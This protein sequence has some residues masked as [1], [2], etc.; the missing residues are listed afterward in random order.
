MFKKYLISLFLVT[1]ICSVT[2]SQDDSKG[3]ITAQ[4]DGNS[5]RSAIKSI[6]TETSY[7]INGGNENEG[8]KIF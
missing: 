3:S 8:I 1:L 2:F 7:E 5:F 6:A 4:I